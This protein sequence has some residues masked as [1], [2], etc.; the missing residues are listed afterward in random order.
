M[1]PF[2]EKLENRWKAGARVCVGPDS[3]IARLPDSL[4]HDPGVDRQLAFNAEIVKATAEIVLA[5]KF[6]IA[7]YPGPEGLGTLSKS[8]GIIRT[9]APDVPVILDSK[10][11]DI[12]N[13]NVG[14][15]KEAFEEID[16][17]AVTLSPYLGRESLKPFLERDDKASIIICRTS[18]PG[19]GEFQ[20]LTVEER[21][22]DRTI[23]K[24]PLYQKV[25]RNVARDWNGNGNCALVVGATV[26]EQLG[27]V[28]KLIGDM[29]ILIP[30]IGA[31]GGELQASVKNG[32]NSQKNGIIINSSRGIIFA[33]SG[34]DFAEAA[35][36]ETER[37]TAD[38]NAALDAA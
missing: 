38:I 17:D 35:R 22:D 18:N 30:G 26:P 34:N 31:Q 24:M 29:P 21:L 32:V 9:F 25:A 33:S 16:A 15:V 3:D 27:E 4:G 37:L 5:Y 36:R 7:F 10:R 8:V 11:G 19:A 6:N 20:D 13:T 2:F 14:Y 23:L 12:G 28:R 1:N